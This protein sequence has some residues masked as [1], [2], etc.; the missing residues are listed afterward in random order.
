MG[1]H[2]TKVNIERK[3]SVKRDSKIE[4]TNNFNITK[5]TQEEPPVKGAGDLIKVEFDFNVDYAP[6]IGN[7]A[8]TG[9]LIFL[10][11]AKVIKTALD[12][13]HKNKKLNQDLSDQIMRPAL[14][15]CNLK[16]LTMSQEVNLPPHLPIIPKAV[17]RKGK[18]ENYIG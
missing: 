9:N 16:A 4:I 8:L 6:K 7:I 17:P 10:D 15:R 5:I 18:A 1:F 12:E 2:F 3:N 11:N 14:Y 13:W